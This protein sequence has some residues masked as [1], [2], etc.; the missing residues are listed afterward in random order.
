MLFIHTW[1]LVV[2]ESKTLTSRLAYRN[3][4]GEYEC[5]YR[6][7]RAYAVQPKYRAASIATIEVVEVFLAPRAREISEED[8]RAEGFASAD[9]Y[10]A[11]CE[12]YFGAAY[13]DKPVFRIRF[14]LIGVGQRRLEFLSEKIIN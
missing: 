9:E 6:A 14:K 1:R 2:E 11:G 3:P 7:G 5:R 10:R 4:A 13:L 8:A 12:K